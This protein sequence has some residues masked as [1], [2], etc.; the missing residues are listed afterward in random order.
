[1]SLAQDPDRVA[2]PA[3]LRRPRRAQR[4]GVD[5][6]VVLARRALRQPAE[7][8]A[9]GRAL[10]SGPKLLIMD[11]PLA[12]LDTERRLEILPLIERLKNELG[13][14]IIYIS[15]SLAEITRLAD[16]LVLMDKGQIK[17]FGPPKTK[18]L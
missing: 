9:I 17:G 13:L 15:H 6:G 12:S 8:V 16:T 7:R 18:F 14:N 1:M 3:D 4:R 10:L 2:V 5:D 11:E